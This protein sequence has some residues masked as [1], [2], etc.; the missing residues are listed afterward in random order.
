[1]NNQPFPRLNPPRIV[2]S[3]LQ[4]LL[5]SGPKGQCILGD[6]RQEFMGICRIS[7]RSAARWY[8]AQAISIG[9][10]YGLAKLGREPR[11]P[12]RLPKRTLGGNLSISTLIQDINYASRSFAKRP[13]FSFAVIGLV[14]LGVGATTTIFS[15]VD[16]VLL[17]KL[18]YPESERLVYF[19]NAAHSVPLFRDWRDR[20]QSFSVVG[21][22]WDANLDL[23]GEG[24]PAKVY[25]GLVT[26]DFFAM[27]D[28]RPEIGRLFTPED[29][30]GYPARTV[31]VSQ[32]M[33]Q[34]RW[35]SDPAVIGSTVTLNG[36]LME[37]VGVVSSEFTPP[38]DVN[39]DFWIPLDVTADDLQRRGRMLLS[40]I[41]RLKPGVA[42]E[43]A[44]SEIDAVSALLANEYP[45]FYRQDDGSPKIYPV[46]PL[47]SATVRDI[48][49]TLYPLL[50][51]VGL[52]LLI[53][54]ANVANLF[55]ARGTDRTREMALRAAL[56]AGRGR[57]VTQLLT[58]SVALA[59]L[60][61]ALGIVLVVFGVSAFE[62]F[63]PGGLPRMESISI[64]LRVLGFALLLSICT[65]VIFG[66]F[67]AFSAAKSDVRSALGDSPGIRLDR[68]RRF[69]LRS[70]LVVAE[71][72]MALMLLMGAG[73]L[74][75]S[76]VTLSNVDIGFE[77]DDVLVVPLN[78][79]SRF[80]GPDRIIFVRDLIERLAALPGVESVGA[81]TTVPP[82]GGRMCCW[83]GGI[84]T[85][86]QPEFEDEWS[87]VAHPITDRYFESIGAQMEQGRSFTR[88][89][90][91][92]AMASAIINKEAALYLFGESNP[93]GKSFWFR[94]S[95]LNVVGVVNDIRHWHLSGEG[96][97]N[98][99][100][101]H[102][103]HGDVGYVEIAIRSSAEPG[104]LA[105]QIRDVVW[106]IDPDLPI[107]EIVQLDRKVAQSI[108][109]PRFLSAL[110][111]TFAA[112]SI[113]LAAGGIYGSLL[114]SVG[115]RHKEMGIRMA[116]GAGSWKVVGMIVRSGLV[117]TVTGLFL[118]V[119]G[120]LALSR[121]LESML[122]GITPTDPGT[123]VIVPLFLGIVALVACYLPARTAARADP[124]A[125]L[126][127]E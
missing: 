121:T 20:S 124:T 15:V 117:L 71:I 46:I 34:R 37:I 105:G 19:D 111:V 102:E 67:P 4:M 75:R 14:A 106:G 99:Y 93:I 54:C 108:A 88:A 79:R 112:L 52:M 40:V 81:G 109:Q 36:D 58:E 53:A 44:Q 113:L 85:D 21:A 84:R 27:L 120:A 114:Y 118:G 13:G 42:L 61:G 94:D 32:G 48:G 125:T 57:I 126:R 49:E 87:T 77:T 25:G 51:A 74:F 69:N 8:W 22:V 122:F 91:D 16:N 86:D 38:A 70:A 95:W 28:A 3:M 43:A 59:V 83:I 30:V 98:L 97:F 96:E 31:I 92:P 115:Q 101:P 119:I 1:M 41:A 18:P 24:T 10:R 64:D 103:L 72:A 78:I 65:G 89:D 110:L 26:E 76:F 60:G 17:D 68:H 12:K 47:K 100:L 23:T 5:P 9:W 63:N 50:G 116:L 33:W 6:L 90:D 127:A 55:L 104:V 73:L 35:G 56:G 82:T 11:S 80:E 62:A 66:I 45:D 2:E 7:R 107:G 123:F 29:F 39:A